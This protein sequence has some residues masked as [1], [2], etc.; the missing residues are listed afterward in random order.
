MGIEHY[1]FAL[2]IAGLVCV[3][4]II[5]KVLFSDVKKQNQMLDER[6]KELNEY[7]NKIET[8]IDEFWDSAKAATDEQKLR[9]Q[10]YRAAMKNLASFE[11]PG[12]LA[13]KEQAI[14]KVPRSLPLDAGRIRI[15]GEVI[16]RAERMISNEQTP[17]SAGRANYAADMAAVNVTPINTYSTPGKTVDTRPES[18]PA[19][20]Q[21]FFD[22]ALEAPPPTPYSPT[23]VTGISRR[24]SIMA[25]ANEGKSDVEIASRL[26]I[27][28]NEVQLVI[29]LTST[30]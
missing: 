22:D 30:G 13:K 9:E 27:T 5:F 3:V 8:I 28:R 4:A 24:D 23:Q 16:E 2:F 26:G 29:G 12:E 14:E 21:S 20:F 1:L 11:L 10:E 19:V 18:K 6:N 15:A 7:Y 17:V 25:L